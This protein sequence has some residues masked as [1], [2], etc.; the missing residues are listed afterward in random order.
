MALDTKQTTAVRKKHG[1]A[2]QDTG[3][4]EVQVALLTENIKQLQPHFAAHPKDHHSRRGLLRMVEKRKKLLRYLE[5]RDPA[6]HQALIQS[7]GLR[8]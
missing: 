2:E 1:R 8:G 5:G 7:L 6:R 4:V 3:S